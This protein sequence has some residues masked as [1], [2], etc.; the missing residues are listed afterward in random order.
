M[1]A[2]TQ[3]S[4]AY[5]LRVFHTPIHLKTSCR[6]F[7]VQVGTLSTITG[8]ATRITGINYWV[9]GVTFEPEITP[10][11]CRGAGMEWSAI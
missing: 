2:C 6:L 8:Q 5:P 4:V 3:S 11:H 10:G 7:L 9:T 1:H